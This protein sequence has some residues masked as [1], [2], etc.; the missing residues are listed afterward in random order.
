MPNKLA[1]YVD[2]KEALS[3]MLTHN[4][5]YAQNKN[6]SILSCDVKCA[7]DTCLDTFKNKA[8]FAVT[9]GC[10]RGSCSCEALDLGKTAY[11]SFSSEIAKR[12]E[13]G[14]PIMPDVEVVPETPEEK[15]VPT[16][17][18]LPVSEEQKP[19]QDAPKEEIEQ[20]ATEVKPVQTETKR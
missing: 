14:L 9:L 6:A 7:K 15:P 1:S 8:P 5:D 18:V 3:Q 20:K 17:P 13:I 11:Q 19:V 16:V 10:I 4:A 12:A 2:G